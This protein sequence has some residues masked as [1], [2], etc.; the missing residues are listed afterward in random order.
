MTLVKICGLSVVDHAMVAA[1]AGADF[2]GVVFAESRRRVTVEKAK[3]IS[4]AIHSRENSPQ[5]VG[6]FAGYSSAEVNRIADY[7]GLDRIQLSGGESWEYCQ[8]IEKPITRTLHIST[9]TTFRRISAD[10][11]AGGRI[12]QG[13]DL[14]FLLDTKVG[15][16]SGGTGRTFD[17]NLAKEVV[18]RFPVLVAGGL[19]PDNVTELIRL[20]HPLGV[21]ISSGVETE[22]RKDPAKIRAFIEAVRNID[23][24]RS[25]GERPLKKG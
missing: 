16:A 24:S 20:A 19:D 7:C 1:E 9:A 11:E 18:A 6:V 2:I 8:Q 22:G 10:I 21:D 13:K 15:N 5:V 14:L 3:K 25:N 4:T 12:L 17:W 23:R